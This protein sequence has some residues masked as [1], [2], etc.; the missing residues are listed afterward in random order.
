MKLKVLT[1]LIKEGLLVRCDEALS[2]RLRMATSLKLVPFDVPVPLALAQMGKVTLD[3]SLVDRTN[4]ARVK[5]ALRLGGKVVIPTTPDLPQDVFVLVGDCWYRL[6]L[7]DADG[8]DPL[9]WLNKNH[10]ICRCLDDGGDLEL[11]AESGR[12]YCTQCGESWYFFEA[13]HHEMEVA[14]QSQ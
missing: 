1:D 4:L 8:N 5:M 13:D 2:L 7:A 11:A 10:H 3:G 6:V 14:F 12:R 9:S